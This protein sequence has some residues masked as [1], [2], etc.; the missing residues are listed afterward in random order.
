[1]TRRAVTPAKMD[2]YANGRRRDSANLTTQRYH[3]ADMERTASDW[4]KEVVL[5]HTNKFSGKG[6]GRTIRIQQMTVKNDKIHIKPAQMN[7]LLTATSYAPPARMTTK[8]KVTAVLVVVVVLLLP[9]VPCT[10]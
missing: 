7:F 8:V 10:P 9:P 5:S 4:K 3:R 2:H 6:K 1:M